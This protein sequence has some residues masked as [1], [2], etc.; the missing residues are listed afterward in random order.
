MAR[1]ASRAAV[2]MVLT[3]HSMWNGRT[4]VVRMVGA[5]AGW[6]DWPA[7]WTA[8]SSAASAEV[9][10]LMPSGRQVVVVPNAVDSDWWGGVAAPSR[11]HAAPRPP[12]ITFVSVMRMVERKRPLALVRCLRQARR[13]TPPDVPM[14]A[15]LVGDG[16]LASIVS[17]ELRRKDMAGWV[18]MTGEVPRERV[19]DVYRDADV[20]VAPA[21]R[22]SFGIAALEARAAGLTVIA[23][24]SG[25]VGDFIADGVEGVLCADDV[26]L[27]HAMA[28]M[29]TRPAM[30]ETMCAHNRAVGPR[31]SWDGTLAAFMRCYE[32][33][34]EMREAARRESDGRGAVGVRLFR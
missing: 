7:V 16:P 15:V 26:G 5:A 6:T 1:H 24:R 13:L 3:V 29:A 2:P 32:R 31:V 14:R 25:G 22:E 34:R 28:T 11:R 20:F 8:V 9:E 30:V 21:D 10:A 4:P 33:A 18:A 19:R 17:D 27:A 23:M 12:P